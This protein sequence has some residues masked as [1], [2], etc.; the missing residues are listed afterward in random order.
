[1]L[2]SYH[3]S[4]NSFSERGLVIRLFISLQ[5]F[6]HVEI[7][8]IYIR[9]VGIHQSLVTMQVLIVVSKLER[10]RILLST[11]VRIRFIHQVAVS[12]FVH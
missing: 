2:L 9:Y 4:C 7:D 12:S 6:L 11:I 1:V 5:M 10:G 3:F 8:E